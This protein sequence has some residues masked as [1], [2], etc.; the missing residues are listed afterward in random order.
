MFFYTTVGG[1]VLIKLESQLYYA[2]GLN[3]ADASALVM[4]LTGRGPS[5]PF[6]KLI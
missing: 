2:I 4:H 6:F 3:A 1:I 5:K